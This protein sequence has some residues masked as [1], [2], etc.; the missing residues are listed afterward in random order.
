MNGLTN[1]LLDNTI[2]RGGVQNASFKIAAKQCLTVRKLIVRK[3]SDEKDEIVSRTD[4]RTNKWT[5]N[6]ISTVAS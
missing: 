5:D 2:S 1:G 4:K 6:A 3:L